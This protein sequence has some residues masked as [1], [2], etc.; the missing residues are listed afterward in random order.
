MQ[1][2]QIPFF[3]IYLN[4]IYINGIVNIA[5][6][7]GNSRSDGTKESIL[8]TTTKVATPLVN[9][10]NKKLAVKDVF[11]LNFNNLRVEYV[12]PNRDTPENI[13][14]TCAIPTIKKF[15]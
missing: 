3:S 6:N 5:V 15:L 4:M 1:N 13:A 8:V 10:P 7:N 2:T 12:M 14:S 9:N 11:L